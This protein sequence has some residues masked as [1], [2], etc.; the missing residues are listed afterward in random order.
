[1]SEVVEL[2]SVKWGLQDLELKK[3]EGLYELFNHPIV[4]YKIL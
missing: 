3:L 1:M 4:S 2:D